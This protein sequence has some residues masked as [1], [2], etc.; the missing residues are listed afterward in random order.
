[1]TMH[2]LS[3]IPLA[4]ITFDNLDPV[5]FW[6]LVALAAVAV[7]GLTYRGI[8]QRSG[9][10]LT[11]ALFGLRLLGVIALLIALVKPAWTRVLER[12]D[13]PQV[14]V[15]IDDSQSISLLHPSDKSG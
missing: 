12:V 14:A 9:K 2:P 11:W 3:A 6:A 10:R 1:M 15:V 8:Y 4:S 13:R 7:L 5:W